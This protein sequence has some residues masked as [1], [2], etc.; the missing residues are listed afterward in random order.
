[1][2]QA[3]LSGSA[4]ARARL[5]RASAANAAAR[6]KASVVRLVPSID[7]R[8]LLGRLCR[9]SDHGI[10]QR[11]RDALA[12]VIPAAHRQDDVLPAVRHVGHR[13]APTSSL[14]KLLASIWSSGEYLL[15]R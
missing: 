7:T 8:E 6:E 5:F 2:A 3:M 14:L 11:E 4:P 10:G 13:R 1:M 9:W 12:A 15:P